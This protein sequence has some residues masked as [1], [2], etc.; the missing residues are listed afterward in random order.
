[1]TSTN[2]EKFQAS[3]CPWCPR[4]ALRHARRPHATPGRHSRTKSMGLQQLL[5]QLRDPDGNSE[6]RGLLP[7]DR[8]ALG[9]RRTQ[10]PRRFRDVP[11]QGAGTVPNTDWQNSGRGRE[12]PP[13]RGS[14][15]LSHGDRW[16]AG[17]DDSRA[18]A[19]RPALNIEQGA[20]PL[21]PKSWR[22]GTSLLSTSPECTPRSVQSMSGVCS[23]ASGLAESGGAA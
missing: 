22:S 12:A 10:E 16:L 4:L 15:L 19:G 8:P 23:S 3:E 5:R 14:R 1:M 17:S 7:Q 9:G 11:R 21:V 6:I 18:G 20:R 13:H 2:G